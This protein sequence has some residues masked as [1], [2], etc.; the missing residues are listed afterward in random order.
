MKN[1]KSEFQIINLNQ[2][3]MKKVI[4]L[5]LAVTFPYVLSPIFGQWEKHII[6][7]SLSDPEI[8]S[9]GDL[10]ND[11]KPD[12]ILDDFNA[13]K[14]FWYENDY[15][16]WIKHTI[17][18][19][20]DGAYHVSV[21][22][23]NGDGKLDVAASGWSARVL[24]WYENNHPVW[25]KHIIDSTHGLAG[26]V[27]IFDVDDD[28]T[29]DV[30][31]AIYD[32]TYPERDFA[33]Y[34][35]NHP[36]WTK[37]VISTDFAVGDFIFGD[38]DG[39]GMMDVAAARWIVRQFVWL[40]NENGVLSWT[41]HII[42]Y[43]VDAGGI[44]LSDLNGDDKVDLVLTTYDD[45]TV[46]W[47]ENNQS[48]WTR[49][50]IDENLDRAHS[51]VVFDIDFDGK[52]DV[53]VT[54][55]QANKVLWYKNNHPEWEKYIIDA[56]LAGP[57]RIACADID[58][59]STLDIIVPG[60]EAGNIVWYRSPGNTA[61]G[62]S[63]EI[64]PLYLNSD[65]DTLHVNAQLFN[66]DNHTVTVFAVINGNGQTFQD[67]IQLFDDGLHGDGD[68]A[69]NIYGGSKWLSGLE[70]N[71]YTMDL[72]TN[73][74]STGTSYCNP[75]QSRFTTIGPVV[76][77]NYT[78]NGADT[79]PEHGEKID[80]KITLRNTG[81]TASA[82][83]VTAKLISLDP[84]V[85]VLS[86]SRSFG[87]IVAGESYTYAGY[88]SIKI[89]EELRANTQLPIV[90]EI[91]SYGYTFWSDTFYITVLEPVKLAKIRE[92]L[93]RIYPN[94]TDNI[95]NIEISN[96]GRQD[97]EIKILDITGTLIYQKEYTS[98][99]A[100][101]VEQ[102]DLSGYAKGIYLVKVRQANSVYVG[103]VIVR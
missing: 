24:V 25:T 55:K 35:N 43:N 17:E 21:G 56:N 23:L 57:H 29:L 48:I 63:L 2:L 97:L 40:K 50:M 45:N 72:S 20:M 54:G 28:D 15:P 100:H 101:F 34:E 37:H 38:I 87:N 33:W 31:L 49:H 27:K 46:V 32:N 102:L 64:S 16:N 86:P 79:I 103:K 52:P 89:S 67:S 42:D 80:L 9:T 11:G 92:P 36:N 68:T 83:N 75:F 10:N 81:S 84:L 12:V 94:P 99:G 7:N 91:A 39:D 3:V 61:H 77:E 51:L 65:G 82:I 60:S 14:I 5:F 85:S 44:S 70:E 47:Y 90:I 93:T 13:G 76:L 4:I 26:C 19:N 59:D 98:S 30:V 69:D 8:V 66:P 18:D 6:D 1:N 95:L 41:K 71:I 53:V 78:F 74:F 58:S 88:F 96:V 62:T 73:D 22:D